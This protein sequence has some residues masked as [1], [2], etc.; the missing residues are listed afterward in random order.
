M[1]FQHAVL[2]LLLM[3]SS[4]IQAQTRDPFLH[5]FA[6]QSIWNLPLHED[7]WLPGN[8]ADANIDVVGLPEY[9]KGEKVRLFVENTSDPL[10]RFHRVRWTNRC[11][12]HA[13]MNV[14]V[15]FPDDY[16]FN[17]AG[18]GQA[19]AAWVMI[20][21]DR[22][23]IWDG[24]V[25]TRC[26]AGGWVGGNANG[27]NFP[28]DIAG[29]GAGP[30]IWGHGA[31]RLSAFGGLIRKGELSSPESEPIRHALKFTIRAQK[32]LADCDIVPAPFTWPAYNHD[33]YACND[34]A[35]NVYRGRNPDFLMGVLLAVPPGVTKDQLNLTT[36]V[37]RKLFDALQTYGAYV[38]EDTGV[39]D[40]WQFHLDEEALAED[41]PQGDHTRFSSNI[42]YQEITRI[43]AELHI[44]T[45]NRPGNIGGG[46]TADHVNRLAPVACPLGVFGSGTLCPSA[47]PGPGS[48]GAPPHDPR[49]MPPHLREVT[50]GVGPAGTQ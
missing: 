6:V 32:Y 31:S 8:H 25:F 1:K 22:S 4:M 50:V 49:P 9:L 20:K 15:H 36:R 48:G 38:V 42:Y 5:P 18:T 41:W 46:P 34:S 47:S 23:T 14:D 37:A 10:R 43:L 12:D 30:N 39:A 7:A 28:Y 16:V 26:E 24:T 3:F 19:N 35:K 29:T 17:G 40:N 2:L 27:P 13:D 33:G 44:I 21:P 11:T 45:S